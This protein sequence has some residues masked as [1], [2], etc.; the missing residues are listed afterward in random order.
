MLLVETGVWVT[1]LFTVLVGR[2]VVQ[3]WG[4]WRQTQD[5]LYGGMWLGFF[6]GHLLSL[7]GCD[8]I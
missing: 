6:G 1:G 8:S 4:H 2:V 3:G 7:P 5:W